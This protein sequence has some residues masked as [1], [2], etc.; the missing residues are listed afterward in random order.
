[1][2]AAGK[3]ADQIS[4]AIQEGFDTGK[5]EAPRRAG[6][7]Y[8]LSPIQELYSPTRGLRTFVPHLMFYG[9]NLTNDDIGAVPGSGSMVFMNATLP[10]GMIIVPLGEKERQAIQNESS[11]LIEKTRRFLDEVHP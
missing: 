5:Y 3:T 6:I 2:R 7:S 4:D 9:P 10:H 11:E 8:M 1:M